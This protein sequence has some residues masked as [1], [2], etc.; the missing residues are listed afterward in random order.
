VCLVRPPPSPPPPSPPPPSP[1]PLLPP[2]MV[3]APSPPPPGTPPPSLP[4]W[5]PGTIFTCTNVCATFARQGNSYLSIDLASDGQ[6][7]DGGPGS[8]FSFCTLAT[9][10]ADCGIR[11]TPGPWF[12]PNPPTPPSP[13]RQPGELPDGTFLV[14][15]RDGVEAASTGLY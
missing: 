13:P 15:T 5:Q 3:P 9:D 4:P 8:E 6:C 10:C 1:P 12:P 7:D 2:P 14:T 11:V